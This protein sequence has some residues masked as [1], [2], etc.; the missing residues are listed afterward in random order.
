MGRGVSWTASK[1]KNLHE[2]SLLQ[3]NSRKARMLLNWS[4]NYNYEKSIKK[5]IDWYKKYYEK[6]HNMT[7]YTLKQIE[8]YETTLT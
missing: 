8:D 6:S 1:D 5:T 4:S 2:S 3:L 7:D